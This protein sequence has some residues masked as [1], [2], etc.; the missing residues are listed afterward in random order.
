[1]KKQNKSLKGGEFTL[2]E[3]LVVISIIAILASMLLPA[4]NKARD[5]AKKIACTSNLK[6]V[7][8]A[9]I[10][11]A[12]DYDSYIPHCYGGGSG[13]KGY[14]SW[15]SLV[16]KYINK[17]IDPLNSKTVDMA[18]MYCPAEPKV[19][20]YMFT[21]YAMN[22]VAGGYKYNWWEGKETNFCKTSRVQSPSM[23]Y[24]VG[25]KLPNTTTGLYAIIRNVLPAADHQEGDINSRVALRH[26]FGG[27]WMYFDG[28]VDWHIG[29]KKWSFTG[30]GYY[31]GKNCY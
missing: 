7:A 21:T 24:L 25:E 5:T 17:S 18:K 22:A 29:S 12:D 20:K 2:I 8:L 6:Q 19:G 23:V 15:N 4:L 3:L 13:D 14:H 27:N 9:M 26:N 11:Y 30:L 31:V 28:H 10:A 16:Y 1:M